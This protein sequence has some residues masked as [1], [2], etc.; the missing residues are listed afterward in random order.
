MANFSLLDDPVIRE[1]AWRFS[2]EQYQALTKAGTLDKNVELL[3]GFI[4]KKMSKSPRHEFF[5]AIL[6]KMLEQA[7]LADHLIRKEGPLLCGNSV[8][9]PDV[10]V[11]LGQPL[12]FFDR[13]PVGAELVIEVALTSTEIDQRK[14]NIYATAQ[15]PEYWIVLPEHRCVE[16]C[17]APFDSDYT[18]TKIYA[19]PQVIASETFP[20]FQLDLAR[21][22]PR[23]S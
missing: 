2:V 12:D 5:T 17:T 9:E 10:A 18:V 6:V 1:H 16:V 15:V 19:D 22:F 4:V 20:A 14:K 8:P 3:D 23:Q 21:F 7:V 11:V 13:H